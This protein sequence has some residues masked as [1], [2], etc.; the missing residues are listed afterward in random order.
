MRCLD[1]EK[2]QNIRFTDDRFGKALDD[3]YEVDRATLMT[4]IVV[5]VVKKFNIDL[6][7]NP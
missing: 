5:E 2:Y 4:K 3:L 1:Y 7:A 6:K